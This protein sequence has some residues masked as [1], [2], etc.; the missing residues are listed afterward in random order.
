M[1]HS[2]IEPVIGGICTSCYFTNDSTARGCTIVLRN[3]ENV[4]LQFRMNRDTDNGIA[5]LMCFTVPQGVFRVTVYE[6]L[7]DGSLGRY[8][9]H[10]PDVNIATS[11]DCDKQSSQSTKSRKK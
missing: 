1:I 2:A 8:I 10:L 6:T 7:N 11:P 4:S 9:H 5:L 3:D